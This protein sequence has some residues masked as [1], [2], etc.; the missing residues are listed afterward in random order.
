MNST[1]YK[2]VT[3]NRKIRFSRNRDTSRVHDE[4]E[5]RQP[6]RGLNTTVV[7]REGGAVSLYTTRGW[8]YVAKLGGGVASR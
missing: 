7:Q 6:H 5:E 3:V 2:I 4:A 1:G 8:G